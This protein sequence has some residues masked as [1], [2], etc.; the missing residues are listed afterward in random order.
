[1]QVPVLHLEVSQEIPAGDVPRADE[2][3][4]QTLG[5]GFPLCLQIQTMQ[6][7]LHVGKAAIE[8]LPE[9]EELK[10]RASAK[11]RG[12]NR[13]FSIRLKRGKH[14]FQLRRAAVQQVVGLREALPAFGAQVHPLHARVPVLLVR[15][16]DPLGC[17]RVLVRVNPSAILCHALVLP[18]LAQ[19]SLVLIQQGRVGLD[20]RLKQSQALFA[21]FEEVA[22]PVVLKVHAR[23]Q[24]SIPRLGTPPPDVARLVYCAVVR[25]HSPRPIHCFYSLLAG[26]RPPARIDATELLARPGLLL[27]L[28]GLLVGRELARSPVEHHADPGD[29]GGLWRE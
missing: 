5:V 19:Q 4:A 1:M 6:L 26:L 18:R 15:P 16:G 24:G 17:K 20:Q 25:R 7:A 13:G 23:R 14:E 12:A 21:A 8:P 9:G 27:G 10:A 2:A 3:E 28:P 11:G 29:L 22:P